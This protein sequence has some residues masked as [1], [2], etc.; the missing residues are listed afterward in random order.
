MAAH[1]YPAKTVLTAAR[2]TRPKAGSS[3]LIQIGIEQLRRRGPPGRL[4][5]C[6]RVK[7][8]KKW[9]SL[10]RRRMIAGPVPGKE[11]INSACLKKGRAFGSALLVD[12]QFECRVHLL[13]VL[14]ATR[15]IGWTIVITALV[16]FARD[17]HRVFM[18][19]IRSRCSC[20]SYAV[21]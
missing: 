15:T 9:L 12:R 11:L 19:L 7:P 4:G 17:T 3:A 20:F 6:L 21:S 16:G 18:A 1:G 5:T 8:F 2:G 10:R 13:L 14:E